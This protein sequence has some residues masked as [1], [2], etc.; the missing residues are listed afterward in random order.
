MVLCDQV[1]NESLE[2]DRSLLRGL[3]FAIHRDTRVDI[4][5]CFDTAIFAFGHD[6]LVHL[7]DDFKLFVA[8]VLVAVSLIAH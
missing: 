1:T 5:L 4:L 2:V 8:K 3:D 6:T 7:A